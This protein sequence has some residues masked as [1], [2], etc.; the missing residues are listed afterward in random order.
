MAVK[1][2]WHHTGLVPRRASTGKCSLQTRYLQGG[3]L[4]R[5]GASLPDAS[6]QTRTRARRTLQLMGWCIAPGALV[7]MSPGG[8][9][10]AVAEPCEA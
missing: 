3:S 9:P 2:S 1:M 10:P 5:H 7:L 8:N 4:A 6:P